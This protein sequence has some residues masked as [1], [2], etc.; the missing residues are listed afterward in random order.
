MSGYSLLD[1]GINSTWALPY[2][3]IHDQKIVGCCGF[4]NKPVF[5]TVEMVIDDEGEELECWE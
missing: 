5:N 4:K 1:Q 2:L 3:I